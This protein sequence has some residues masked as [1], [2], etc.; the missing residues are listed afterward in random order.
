MSLPAALR[1]ERHGEVGSTQDLVKEELARGR[2]VDG[3][4]VRA[5]AQLRGRGRLE[6]TWSSGAGGSYQTI[7]V[8]DADGVLRR[9]RV[10][11]AIAVGIAE[12]LAAQGVA[13]GLKWPNDLYL[14]GDLAGR[15]KPAHA[16][17]GKLGGILCEHV[18]GHLLVGVGINVRNLVP[19]GAAAL[20]GH[21]PET[22]SDLVLAGVRNGLGD[23]LDAADLPDRFSRF[24]ILAGR[25]LRVAEGG[26]D[27]V[28]KGAGVDDEGCLRLA[29]LSGSRTTC[30]GRIVEIDA[31]AIGRD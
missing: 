2:E 27:L 10:P 30:S 28:G 4:V 14:R 31:A 24:D 17:T 9:G 29:T 15:T 7:V 16:L 18:R 20:T 25:A 13:I 1:I 11:I 5:A 23:L 21:E 8:R 6:R 26:R 22:V 19:T 12:S 3:L